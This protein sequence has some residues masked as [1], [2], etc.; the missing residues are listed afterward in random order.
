M[1]LAV[2]IFQ[3]INTFSLDILAN[4]LVTHMHLIPCKFHI[5]DTFGCGMHTYEMFFFKK[6]RMHNSDMH[7]I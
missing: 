5:G 4:D 1:E 3:N 7:N 6:L 2:Y